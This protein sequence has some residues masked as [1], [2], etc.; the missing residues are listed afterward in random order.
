[1][2]SD[3]EV[4][5]V[6]IGVSNLS[7]IN[8]L[9][10]HGARVFAM[11][12]KTREELG[13]TAAT[14]EAKGVTLR[15]GPGYL[16]ELHRYELVFLTP[17]MKKDLPEVE[18]ARESG[19]R[20]DS[21]MGLFLSLC[22]GR[23]VAVTGSAGKTTTTTL[24]GEMLK[25]SGRNVFVGG[26]IGT[27]LIEHLDEITEQDVVVLELSSFQLEL[28]KVSPQVA[29][30]TNI[31]VDHLDV[32]GS[33][34]AY[35]DAKKNIFRFQRPEDITA[36]NA[37]NEIT[38]ALAPEC[39]GRVLF[40]SRQSQLDQGA[41]LKDDRLYVHLDGREHVLCKASEVGIH[42][43][44]NLEN[45]L[46]ASLLSISAGADADAVSSVLVSFKGVEHR[47]ETVC[48]CDGV[49]YVN[50]SIATSP[51][52]AIAALRALPAPILLIAGGYD[53]GLSYTDYARAMRGKVRMLFTL[54]KTADKIER[55]VREELG[56]DA[57]PIQRVDSLE[58]AVMR[59]HE[60][61]R[62][63]DTVLLSPASASYDMFR[64]FEE[65]GQRFKQ[66]VREMVGK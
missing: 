64:N 59:A 33:V 55:A 15:L 39:P 26:N 37:D 17:G 20:I 8:Y 13:Q 19:A 44:H 10:G 22:R 32:H 63:G 43:P 61:A 3:R 6:G 52:R 51:V 30:I 66:L 27:P 18:R 50:D 60:E 12:R 29:G 45:A 16:D 56:D 54:G 1:V 41:F 5:V 14:L 48:E 34:E 47:L 21:E 40:F 62:V 36:L 31:G 25:A 23:T 65:R 2:F 7:L 38:R 42:G 49:R 58:Q 28:T 11:D 53:K 57:M 35:R 24:T 4:A 9:L 46:L